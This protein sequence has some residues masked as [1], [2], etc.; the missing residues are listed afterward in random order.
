MS[1]TAWHRFA[2]DNKRDTA[3]YIVP[4]IILIVGLLFLF[5]AYWHVPDRSQ[6]LMA[7]GVGLLVAG[8]A[9]LIGGLIGFLF[10]L[11]RKVSATRTATTTTGDD[12][13]YDANT[14]LEQISDWLTKILLGAGLTQ[15]GSIVHYIGNLAELAG[16][17]LPYVPAESTIILAEFAYFSVAGF[18]AFYLWTRVKITA[19][20]SDAER[21][22]KELCQRQKGDAKAKADARAIDLAKCQ[23]GDGEEKPSKTD[24]EQAIRDANPDVRALIFFRA[25][26]QRLQNEQNAAD[27]QALLRT[28]PVFEALIASDTDG[29]YHAN[30]G[31]I[32]F[33]WKGDSQWQKAIARLTEAIDIRKEHPSPNDQPYWH[34]YEGA[35]AVCNIRL[36]EA[37][38]NGQPSPPEICEPILSDLSLAFDDKE[39]WPGILALSKAWLQLNGRAWLKAKNITVPEN[40]P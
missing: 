38:R 40:H 33:A 32:G 2:A 18:L 8:G 26:K 17:N 29:V 15:A 23:L 22:R 37:V 25:Q 28:I 10:G 4:F 1:E 7:L 30:H 16:K 3:P 39:I 35:R 9:T 36:D 24:L 27:R 31:E 11:P 20:F 12:D 34:A 14:N 6:Y 13:S 19:A 5:P 21:L